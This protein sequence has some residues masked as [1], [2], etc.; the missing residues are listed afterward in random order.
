MTNLRT[1]ARRLKRGLYRIQH[2]N[3]PVDGD[4][5][6]VSR[7]EWEKRAQEGEFR[8]HKRDRW[9]QTDDF[10][11][12]TDRVFR[13]FGFNPNDYAGK[14]VVDVGAGSKLRTKFFEDARLVVIEPL[15]DRFLAEIK[16][17]DLKDAAEVHSRPAEQLV[18]T[19]VGN[20]D[21]VVSINVLDHCFDFP[22][23]V[24]NIRQY[25]KPD[26]VAFLSF[27]MHAEAD[28]MHPL[29]LTEE[30]CS[31]IF[32][33]A[34]L[35]IEKVTTGMG[36]ALGGVQTYGHGPFTLNYWLRPAL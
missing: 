21:L 13:H 34:G 20:A 4:I 16:G 33:E 5:T 32:A 27:D 29:T 11:V 2:R 3:R 7:D 1:V 24:K 15:G 30:S 23:I 31:P 22:Q 35:A 26:G 12:Q 36:D 10:M 25:L 14:T 28:S 9:R 19:L 6:A 17:C 18:E 8:F